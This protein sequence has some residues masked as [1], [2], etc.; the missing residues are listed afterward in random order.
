M[1]DGDLSR[2]HGRLDALEATLSLLLG[3]L[4]KHDGEAITAALAKLLWDS[5]EHSA[6]FGARPTA[7]AYEAQ[8][9]RLQDRLP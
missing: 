6:Q 5:Q 3:R 9:K 7:V 2:I 4:S 1:D 8:I